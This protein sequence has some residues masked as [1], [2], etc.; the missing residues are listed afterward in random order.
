MTRRAH[1]GSVVSS[2]SSSS[3]S[4]GFRRRGFAL[5]VSCPVKTVSGISSIPGTGWPVV[6]RSTMC[7]NE[8]GYAGS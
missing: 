8:D 7:A 6:M 3:F 1:R 5:A 2:A 4:H